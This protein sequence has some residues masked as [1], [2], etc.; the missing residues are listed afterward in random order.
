MHGQPPGAV[1]E[2]LGFDALDDRAVIVLGQHAGDGILQ[3]E[4]FPED[5]GGH[6]AI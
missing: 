2:L 4:T 1:D 5:Q 3:V 6:A